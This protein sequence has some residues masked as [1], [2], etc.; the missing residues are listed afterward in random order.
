MANKVQ[1]RV[2]LRHFM[3]GDW[4]DR[5]KAFRLMMDAFRR[6]VGDAGIRQAYY[7]HQE[8]TSKSRKIRHRKH[9]ARIE[10]QMDQLER[11]ILGGETIRT[12]T[13]MVKRVMQR[14]KN[15]KRREER[16]WY[17]T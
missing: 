12:N 4:F 8:F 13:Q 1:V 5:D 16:S 9:L 2:E 11:R 10:Q 6:K 3:K 7:E 15:R 17:H 14:L